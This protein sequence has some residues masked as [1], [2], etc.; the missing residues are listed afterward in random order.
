M[1]KHEGASLRRPV[2]PAP[3]PPREARSLDRMLRSHQLDGQLGVRL[4]I[5]SEALAHWIA[6][7]SDLRS[8]LRRLRR[9][10]ILLADPL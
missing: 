2:P 3:E 8:A 4:S 5:G 9:Q 6:R 7:V 10:T 1:S